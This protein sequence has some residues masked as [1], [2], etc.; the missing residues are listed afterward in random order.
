MSQVTHFTLSAALNEVMPEFM[1]A[2]QEGVSD[3][4]QCMNSQQLAEA[5]SGKEPSLDDLK[6]A[7]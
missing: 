2:V 7:A 5:F 4:I 6:L 1:N 3:A